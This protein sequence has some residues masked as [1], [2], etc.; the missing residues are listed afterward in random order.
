MRYPDISDLA[1]ERATS[2][3]FAGAISWEN[4][5]DAADEFLSVTGHPMHLSLFVSRDNGE[6]ELA[7][8]LERLIDRSSWSDGVAI[9]RSSEDRLSSGV[10]AQIP[11]SDVW[12]VITP[13]D[14]KLFR[15][16][17][18]KL[19]RL[20]FPWSW[21][22]NYSSK[23]LSNIVTSATES[24]DVTDVR[25]LECVVRSIIPDNS[26][27]KSVRSER[28]WTDEIASEVFLRVHEEGK[29]FSSVQC[30]LI[31]QGNDVARFTL[32]RVGEIGILN[33]IGLINRS[34]IQKACEHATNDAK[35]LRN[36]SRESS[37]T[38]TATPV[39][40]QYDDAIFEDKEQNH[41][42]ISVLQS[43]PKSSV[44]IIHGNPYVRASLTDYR[45]G[46]GYAIW[47]LS[48]DR[49][50]IRPKTRSTEASFVSLCNHICDE[51]KEGSLSDYT[52]GSN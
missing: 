2:K 1:L 45:D 26:S 8:Q 51:F 46:S 35:F 47:V 40:I 23:A 6:G 41:R 33:N 42:L 34:I 50:L 21:R 10:I 22:P 49:I 52:P 5:L 32:N 18:E 3:F 11:E 4:T 24:A 28:V 48:T 15:N 38:H 36:R 7:E 19:S 25:M 29:W 20:C 13:E 31:N 27:S 44:S 9:F 37:T 39:I 12:I 30:S 43:F 14:T 17:V 16:S